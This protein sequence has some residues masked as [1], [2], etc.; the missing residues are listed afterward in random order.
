MVTITKAA[1]RNTRGSKYNK[2]SKISF[3]LEPT[4][5]SSS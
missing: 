5:D 4:P 3:V 2:I 1:P